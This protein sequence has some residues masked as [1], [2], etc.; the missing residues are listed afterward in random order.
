[1][2]R[3]R[4]KLRIV[5]L[6]LIFL[7]PVLLLFCA[8]AF[9]AIFQLMRQSQVRL[10]TSESYMSQVYLMDQLDRQEDPAAQR[11]QLRASAPLLCGTLA[12]ITSL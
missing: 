1:M 3:E 5:R 8:A 9:S 7:L 4:L 11:T 2:I 12:E 6:N 10:L